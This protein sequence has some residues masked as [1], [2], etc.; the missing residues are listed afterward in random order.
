MTA[1][2]DTSF[3][4]A[5]LN[6]IDIH[7]AACRVVY[8]RESRIYLPQSALAEV[9]YMLRRE[10][11][12]AQVIGF[13]AKLP[14]SKYEVMALTPEDIQRT[15]EILQNYAD[16]RIDFVDASIAA[17]AER[18]S[19]TRILTLDRRD[20]SLMRPDHVPHFELLPAAP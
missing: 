11:G 1:F 18:M 8:R 2:A 19:V 4:V 9:A 7:H 12:A 6:P 10:A 16:T 14:S 17:A 3:V 5:I 20:F 15:A 13:L